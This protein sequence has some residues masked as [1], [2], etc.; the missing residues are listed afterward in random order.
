MSC[1]WHVT[2]RLRR[3]PACLAPTSVQQNSQLRLPIGITR[4]ARSRWF[5]QVLPLDPFH[6]RRSASVVDAEHCAKRAG[7]REQRRRVTAYTTTA[8][9]RGGSSGRGPDRREPAAGPSTSDASERQHHDERRATCFA[10]YFWNTCNALSQCGEKRVARRS[11]SR[12]WLIAWMVFQMP[13]SSPKTS[14]QNAEFS[15]L[16]F[17]KRGSVAPSLTKF[18]RALYAVRCG[19]SGSMMEVEM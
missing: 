11:S 4:S 14:F 13:S 5:A 9:P 6:L 17:S 19:P 10:T 3:M 8:I 16:S 7:A 15:S 18:V 12:T 1:S 2:T